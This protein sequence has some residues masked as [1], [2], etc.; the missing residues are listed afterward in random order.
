MAIVKEYRLTKEGLAELEQELAELKAQ[1]PVVA[2]KIKTARE[3]GDLAENDEYSNARDEQTRTEGRITEIE[4][5]LQ[6]YELIK[7]DKRSD[8]VKLGNT[9]VMVN[10]DKKEVTYNI[11]GSI[12]ADPTERKI[13]DESPIGQAL[14]GKKV[15][16]K[17]EIELPAGKTVYKI[18]AIS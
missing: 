4:Y 10:S 7:D 15:G 8:I 13:S 5:I 18:K 1:R 9:V 3:F 12:E 17:V 11:V 14:L 2:E 16:D 6:N